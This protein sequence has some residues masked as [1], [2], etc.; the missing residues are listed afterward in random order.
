[1]DINWATGVI[2]VYKTDTFMSLVSGTVYQMDT[3]G[4]RLALKDDEDGNIGMIFPDTHRHNTTV[5]L[6]GVTYARVLEILSPYTVT[7]DDAGGAWTCLLSGSNNNV[8]DVVN[9]STVQLLAANSAGLVEIDSGSGVTEQDKTDIVNGV[10]DKEVNGTVAGSY[11]EVVK[12]SAFHG[13]AVY[14]D[15]AGGSPGTAFPLG[16]INA[17]SSNITDAVTIATTNGL[18]KIR[19][20]EDV[21]IGATDDVSGLLIMGAHAAKSEITVT[22]GAVTTFTQ[23]QNCTLTGTLNGWVIVRDSVLDDV[24]GFQGICHQVAFHAG[25][26]VLG[27]T[28]VSYFLDCYGGDPGANP[29]EIDFNGSG[30]TC[31][32]RNL[33]GTVKLVNKTGVHAVEVNLNAGGVVLDTTVTAGS[34]VVDGNGRLIDT[35]DAVIDDGTWNGGVTVTNDTMNPHHVTNHVWA[36]DVA[37]E[38]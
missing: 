34:I 24:T 11:G 23:F 33:S 21:T 10:W 19:V 32:L 7:F 25:A 3:D 36:K 29:T 15:V 2:T 8:L 14:V 22:A 37:P 17:P 35:L 38:I 12:T 26:V 5:V 6:S 18:D 16:T 30:P 4:F 20:A 28:A 31:A 13:N 1:M 27:G 9:Y